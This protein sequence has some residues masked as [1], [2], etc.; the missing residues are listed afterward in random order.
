V[1]VKGVVLLLMMAI[2]V[3]GANVGVSPSPSWLIQVSPSGPSPSSKEY[4]DGYYISFIDRQFHLENK[5]SYTRVIREI[6]TESGVQNGSEINVVFD[7]SYE[8]LDFHYIKVWRDGKESSRL[9]PSDMKVMPV[10]TDRQRFIYNGN[11]S[12]SLVLPDIRKGDKIELAYSRIGWNPVFMNK[13]S[14]TFNFSTYDYL[15][16]LHFAIFTREGRQ[17]QFKDFNKPPKKSI[18]KINGLQVYE[19]ERK[20]IKRTTYDDNVPSWL[21]ND[22]FVQISEFKSWSEVIAWGLQ[23]YEASPE[24]PVVARKVRELKKKSQSQ[25]HYLELATRFVQDEI[26]YLGVET[27]VNSHKPHR[28]EQV[29]VQRYGDCKDKALLLCTLLKADGITSSPLLVD[30]YRKGHVQEYLPSPLVFNHVVVVATLDKRHLF[31]DGTYSLQG[32]KAPTIYMPA[33]GAGMPIIK[34]AAKL[35]NI[36]VRNPG[37]VEVTEEY[38]LPSRFDST[39]SGNLVIKSVYFEGEADNMRGSLQD[40]SLSETIEGYLKYYRETYPK[41]GVEIQDTLESIDQ[42][43]AN[44]ISLIERYSLSDMWA[45]DSTRSN[46]Y[47]SLWGKMMYDQL[48]RLPKEKRRDPLSIGYPYHLKYKILLRSGMELSI[49]KDNWDVKR[50][51][52]EMRVATSYNE[53]EKALELEYEYRTLEDH[54]EVVDME[55]FRA[56]VKKM[57]N[58]LEYEFRNTENSVPGEQTNQWLVVLRLVFIVLVAVMLVRLYKYSPLQRIARMN[59]GKMGGPLIL[60]GIVVC[61]QPVLLL[62][63]TAV[64]SSSWL[65]TLKAWNAFAG[66][67][68]LELYS[69]RGILVLNCL[70][71]S[72][73]LAFSVLVI[74]LFF[75]K[76][77]SFSVM[78]SIF[79]VVKVVSLGLD[80]YLYGRVIELGMGTES[81][82]TRQ[83]IVYWLVF[84]SISLS[85]LNKSSQSRNTF[86]NVFEEDHE[87]VTSD[88]VV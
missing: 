56:D 3:I 14:A 75:K 61:C 86:V 58:N 32:G 59:A 81:V 54:I 34:G 55:Q 2:E 31:I 68:F 45:Y 23:F 8:R 44:N 57:T 36:P 20:D 66:Q 80:F 64:D 83:L 40:A 52:Y 29:I 5:V 9:K 50:K 77:D 63:S 47:F 16:H 82:W 33:Y 79:I 4:S 87:K 24:S 28:P 42:R 88:P 62:A 22:Q 6:V 11:Y 60:I 1:V 71:Q 49:S 78:F 10:E 39:R 38:Y 17:L 18:Q 21:D 48:Y 37:S 73:L 85:Y 84:G 35:T 51:A 65:Y 26:R 74:I 70:L 41:I 12:A 43:E 7:P 27:G 13:Y 25:A 76:R 15:G 67:A 72:W 53:K 69:F 19:W 30:T 46:Y